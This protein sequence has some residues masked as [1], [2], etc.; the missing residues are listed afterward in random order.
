MSVHSEREVRF[1]TVYALQ[2]NITVSELPS[3]ARTACALGL[4]DGVHAGHTA[5]LCQ[6]VRQ[7]RQNGYLPIVYTFL[8]GTYKNTQEIT[9]LQ[10]RLELFAK[11]GI[12]YAVLADFESV[13]GQSA[14]DFIHD[15]L[16]GQLQV[17]IA[18]CGENFCFG[19][20]RVG[21][22]ALLGAELAKAGAVCHIVPCVCFSSCGAFALPDSALARYGTCSAC[23]TPISSTV[24][25]TM[26][27]QGEVDWAHILL[28]RPYTITAPVIT[29]RQIGRTLGFPTANQ[30]YPENKVLLPNGVYL[31]YATTPQG[32]MLYGVCNVGQSPTI[33]GETA[34]H[35]ESHF[36]DCKEDFYGQ[37]LTVAFLRRERTE[38]TFSS[39]EELKEA[40][41]KNVAVARD[42]FQK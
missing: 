9:T 30:V 18:L 39:L 33:A 27:R 32:Q 5:L 36:L 24:I 7:A 26:L 22:V 37:K 17:Q 29:G 11:A 34:L 35:L 13:K 10:E 2:P 6:T 21:T 42:Y 8:Q 31:C 40:I 19:A 15:T 25:R 14:L 23:Q 1:V 28:G 38:Q 16:L 41:A 4:F 20:A 3:G 12:A